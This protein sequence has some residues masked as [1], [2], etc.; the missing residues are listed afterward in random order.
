M[1]KYFFTFLIISTELFSQTSNTLL[2]VETKDF[3]DLEVKVIDNDTYDIKTLGNDPYFFLNPLSSD[4]SKTNSRLSFEYFCPT[5]LDFIEV[6]FYPIK[7]V[8]RSKK[9]GDIGSTEAWVEFSID[10]KDELIYWGKKGDFLR[11][12]FGSAANLNIQIRNL[13]IRSVTQRELEIEA[14]KEENRK[15]E[16]I[17]ENGINRYLDDSNKYE[18][19]ITN[20]LVKNRKIEIEADVT[21]EKKI[22]IG[23]V[24]PYEHITELTEFKFVKK[25]KNKNG[26]VQIT[27]DRSINRNGF[28][29]DRVLSKW[30]LLEKNKNK[31]RPIS[32][33]H[34]ADSIVA[35]HN[36]LFKKPITKKGLG[37]YSVNGK[38]PASDLDDLG[39]SSVTVNIRI[40]GIYRSKASNENIPFT[41]MGKTYYIDKKAIKRFDKTIKSASDKNIEVS[42]IT[43]IAKEKQSPDKIIG[44]ILQHPD[45]DPAGVYAMPN[46]TNVEGVQYYAAILDFLANRYT[47]PDKKYGRIHHWIVHNEVDAGWVWTNAGEKTAKVYM[48]LYYKSMRITN[49]I[50][51]Q[52]NTNSKVF[53]SLTHY[54]NWTSNPHFYH[55]KDLL[56]QLLQYSKVEGDF[57]WA[58]AQHPYPESLREP[59]TWL[60]KKLSYDFDSELITFKNLEVLD[61][62][63]KQP[64]VLYKGKIKRLVYLSEN[65]TNSPTYSK[66][67]M[68]E[69]AAGLA[70]ALKK[71][72]YLDGIDGFQYHNWQDNRKEGGLRIGLRK[73]PDDD[74]DPSGIKPAWK[75]YQAYGT[76]NEDEIFDKYLSIIG[77]KC[78]EEIIKEVIFE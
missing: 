40:N 21:C 18:N 13:K 63:V 48:D 15:A 34:Y 25:V 27:V 17:L 38:A 28:N 55:S 46:V 4:L 3:N 64:K 75:V 30:V 45:C 11:L 31:Y 5:G 39:I 49:N 65:G 9:I 7:D 8:I 37:G 51:K 60:D 69:Q 74:K 59:K 10:I 62:W 68:I 52:Y 32:S 35:K 12:D 41:Y 61:A 20:V 57:D 33:G 42:A 14:V 53:I 58:I 44:K 24:A 22:Y 16:A 76:N 43:L 50:V 54:W 2:E 73:F 19:K 29:Q 77:I 47:R 56:E 23:E 78:W 36:Y 70:Y 72:S 67:D 71:M 6:Y 26:H 1:L 66:K